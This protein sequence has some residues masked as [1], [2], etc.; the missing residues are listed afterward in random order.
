MSAFLSLHLE[1]GWEESPNRTFL[2]LS[3][4]P[5]WCVSV[6]QLL[7]APPLQAASPNKK[8]GRR[9]NRVPFQA[10]QNDQSFTATQLKEA[11]LRVLQAVWAWR[12][13][14][15]PPKRAR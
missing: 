6:G 11:A 12:W 5:L 13:S 8:R 7:R 9:G 2:T 10:R 4:N 3:G 15:K 14:V 1:A